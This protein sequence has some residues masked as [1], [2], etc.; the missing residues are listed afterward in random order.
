MIEAITAKLEVLHPPQ[1]LLIE[2]INPERYLSGPLRLALVGHDFY[3]KGGLEVLIAMD[4]LVDEGSDVEL[5]IAGKMAAGDYASKAGEREVARAEALMEKMGQRVRR[6]GSVPGDQV[7][8]LL[9]ASHILCLPTWGDTYGYS[10]LEG[11]AAG[12]PA[13]TTNIR[14]LPEVNNNACGWVVKVP[15]REGGD[16]DLDTGEKRE[17]FREILV[18]GIV[19]SLR[20]ACSDR[21]LLVRKAQASLARISEEHDLEKHAARLMEIYQRESR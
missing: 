17:A 4:R 14:A 19:A 15:K 7:L 21:E 3:R 8:A 1:E 18:N 2:Q 9:K 20:D 5:T 11:Q 13:I 12:C 10:V 6:L 16:G